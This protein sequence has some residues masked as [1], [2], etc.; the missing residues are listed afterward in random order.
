MDVLWGLGARYCV[1][2]DAHVFMWLWG[3]LL[4]LAATGFVVRRRGRPFEAAVLLFLTLCTGALGLVIFSACYSTAPYQMGLGA[5]NI[6]ARTLSALTCL[7]LGAFTLAFLWTVVALS[8]GGALGLVAWGRSDGTSAALRA[9]LYIG[10]ACLLV[11]AAGAGF[12][13]SFNFSWC[14][15]QR[16]F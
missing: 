16:L 13:G 9:S 5:L 7:S 12:I 3:L 6:S 11:V 15:S 10:A 8:L 2:Q 4:T 1:R 14:A